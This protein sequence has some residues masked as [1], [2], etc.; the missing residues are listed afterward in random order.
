MRCDDI[1]MNETPTKVKFHRTFYGKQRAQ[2]N[3][4]YVTMF[5]HLNLFSYPYKAH[6]YCAIPD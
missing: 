4:K 6:S 3:K 5:E 2:S 1:N